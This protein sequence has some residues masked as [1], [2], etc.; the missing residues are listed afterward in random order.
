MIAAMV[1]LMANMPPGKVIKPNMTAKERIQISTK[2]KDE[3]VK[4]IGDEMAEIKTSKGKIIA[5]LYAKQAPITVGNF[6]K[7]A[8]LG[9]Y[10]GL[11]FHRY[12]KDFVIQGGDPLGTGMGGAGYNIPLEVKKTL[13][14]VTGALGM[15]RSADPNSA[16][17]QFYITLK[18]THFLDGKYAVFGKVV[19]GMKTVLSLR[20]GDTI[21]SINVFHENKVKTIKKKVIK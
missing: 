16:S 13:T 3:K 14:H 2:Y 5:K 9:F 8:R 18:P 20:Q 19:S 15:A 21:R 11:I 10:D 17:S 4:L 7:L 6:V 12:V 1:V